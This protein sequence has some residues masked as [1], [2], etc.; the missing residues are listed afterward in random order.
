MKEFKF[1]VVETFQIMDEVQCEL[2][3]PIEYYYDSAIESILSVVGLGDFRTEIRNIEQ[4]D[5]TLV[6]YDVSIYYDY[7]N[8]NFEI[9]TISCIV[10]NSNG[11]IDFYVKRY[12]HE[13]YL[14]L[15]CH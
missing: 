9:V 15:I 10:E 5:A 14:Q 11:F 13:E 3:H 4:C 1:L 2:E 12:P 8:N 7:F 6:I